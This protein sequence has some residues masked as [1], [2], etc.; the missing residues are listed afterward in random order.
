MALDARKRLIPS[1][2]PPFARAEANEKNRPLEKGR[3]EGEALSFLQQ[4]GVISRDFM[5]RF[6]K[7]QEKSTGSEK[8]FPCPAK[9]GRY[10]LAGGNETFESELKEEAETI[11]LC[12][13]KDGYYIKVVESTKS[14]RGAC[15]CGV[16]VCVRCQQILEP[17]KV[18]E[19]KCHAN[20]KK[21]GE[22]MD[23]ATLALLQSTGKRCP[24][25]SKFVVKNGGCH[26]MMCGTN[27]HGNLLTAI[28]NGGC[29]HQFDWNTLAPANT[30]YHDANGVR[31]SGFISKEDRLKAIQMYAKEQGRTLK[32]PS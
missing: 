5:F 28:R 1:P 7:Q 4:R 13:G 32:M 2:L 18:K 8:W 3:I 29:G 21:T 12:P 10:L 25:C 24:N 31:K 19:H 6:I 26:F 20:E 17:G 30:F 23:K 9:C 11:V 22:A 27:A 14:M 15:E 16:I